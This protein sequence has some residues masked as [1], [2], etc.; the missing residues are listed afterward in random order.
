MKIWKV[1]FGRNS[2]GG[3]DVLNSVNVKIECGRNSAGRDI[4]TKRNIGLGSSA[5]IAHFRSSSPWVPSRIL[6]NS[7]SI[8]ISTGLHHRSG[9]FHP[10]NLLAHA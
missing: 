10:M 9:A 6:D 1:G 8:T 4:P 5:R 3:V 2:S 7:Q